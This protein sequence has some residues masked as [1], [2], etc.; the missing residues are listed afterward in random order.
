MTAPITE[1]NLKSNLHL[2]V[3]QLPSQNFLLLATFFLFSLYGLRD[4]F[5]QNVVPQHRAECPPK[6]HYG[7]T[8]LIMLLKCFPSQWLQG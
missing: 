5:K 8:V 4:I 6:S 3:F 7:L 2:P 1:R